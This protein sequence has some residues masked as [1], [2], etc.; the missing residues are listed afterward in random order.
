MES[1]RKSFKSAQGSH[2]YTCR[3]SAEAQEQNHELQPILLDLDE[4]MS[5]SDSS[6]NHREVV[7]NIDG[8]NNSN[9]HNGKNANSRESDGE[10][11]GQ[12]GAADADGFSFHQRPQGPDGPLPKLIVQFL[13]EQTASGEIAL[14]KD[15]LRYDRNL[16]PMTESPMNH[17][18]TSSREL[19]ASFQGSSPTWVETA[20]KLVRR[21]YTS[22]FEEDE[23]NQIKQHNGGSSN[24]GG[25]SANSSGR[26]RGEVLRCTS[27]ASYRRNSSLLKAKTKS[28]LMDPP[29]DQDRKS[30]RVAKS[31]QVKSGMLGRINNEDEDD[32]F[33]Q[34]DVPEE[35]KKGNIS[36]LTLLEWVS[37]ILILATL[38]CSLSIPA[39]S[40]KLVWRLHLWKWEVLVLVVIC[41]R[42]VSGWG[43]RLVVFFIERNFLLRKRVLYFV[44][45][46]RKAVKNCIWLGLVLI[47]WHAML[48]KKVARETNTSILPF[49]TKILFC[50]LVA[51]LIWLVKTLLVKVLASSF[52][53][54]TYFDRI[55]ESLFNQY[56]IETLSGPPLIEIQHAQEENEKVMA[57]V[58]NLQNAGATMPP[59]LRATVLPTT[60]SGKVIGSGGLQRSPKAGKSG[61]VSKQQDEGI[62]ID[63]LHKLNQK[64]I[65][66]WNM[67]RLMNIVRHG[68]LSTLDETILG[69]AHTDESTMQI[70]SECEA[71]AAAKKI[72]NNVAMGGSKYIYLE[73]LMRFLREDE[74][75]KTMSLFEGATES[76]R[77]SKSA[78]KNWVVGYFLVCFSPSCSEEHVFRACNPW[79]SAIQRDG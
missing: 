25:G 41:G 21:R 46:V 5:K 38:V 19:K 27:S 73:D 67:K 37:L 12:S 60:R 4:R 75:S 40:K 44:Y 63:H 53:V 56:V 28:R 16:P 59:D 1:L 9:R 33:S 22:S 39:L 65:S 69:S 2:K 66:A 34:E 61:T 72:F 11:A 77:I 18:Q 64:N 36:A 8:N 49:V 70:R 13:H 58:R 43:I 55:Q 50:F 31:G 79:L 10:N 47:A 3:I 29:E 35:Y 62:T 48:D 17:R 7:L 57:E 74:A 26:G 42:L 24:I 68:V 45:G 15:E 14:D 76:K 52:H 20:Q 51:T 78:L 54:S 6:D 71:K 23:H 30:G 32:S